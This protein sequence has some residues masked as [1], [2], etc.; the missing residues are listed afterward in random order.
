MHD[1]TS[2]AD[3]VRVLLTQA[4]QCAGQ[5][6]DEDALRLNRQAMTTAMAAFQQQGKGELLHLA[7]IAYRGVAV[8]AFLT[9]RNAEGSTALATGLANA[10]LGLRHWPDAP[11]LLQEQE[12]L[13]SLERKTGSKGSVYIPDD[14]SEWLFDD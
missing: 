10:V 13:L 8:C 9:G 3:E 11:P 4:A 14:F 7:L 12:L 2:A 5:K 1:Q 6:R